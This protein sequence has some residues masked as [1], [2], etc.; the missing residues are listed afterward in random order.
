MNKVCLQGADQAVDRYQLMPSALTFESKFANLAPLLGGCGALSFKAQF[1]TFKASSG[2]KWN[3]QYTYVV[4]FWFFFL[5]ET[6]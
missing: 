4:V 2:T 5:C 6:N 3:T 1:V